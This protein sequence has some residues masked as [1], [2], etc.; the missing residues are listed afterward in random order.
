M[1][2]SLLAALKECDLQPLL[3]VAAIFFSYIGKICSE[4]KG[5]GCMF[6]EC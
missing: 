5:R 2:H 4:G 6:F 1:Y 3:W